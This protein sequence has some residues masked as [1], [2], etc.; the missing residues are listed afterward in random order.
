MLD[1]DLKKFNEQIADK[2]EHI[3]IAIPR[4]YI[5]QFAEDNCGRK[6]TD[7]ELEELSWLAWEES[8]HL[9]EWLDEAIS[10]ILPEEEIVKHREQMFKGSHEIKGDNQPKPKRDK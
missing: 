8:W 10:Q 6:L 5:Q 3:I 1:D 7:A 9:D 2:D 4:G